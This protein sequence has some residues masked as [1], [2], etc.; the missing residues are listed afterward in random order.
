MISLVAEVLWTIVFLVGFLG[1]FF[2]LLSLARA[3]YRVGARLSTTGWRISAWGAI[4]LLVL[5]LIG[6][7]PAGVV[8]FKDRANIG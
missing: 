8:L 7:I 6:L 2:V 4:V 5:P 3:L 1:Y